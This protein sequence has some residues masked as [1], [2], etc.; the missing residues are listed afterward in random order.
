M[1]IKSSI[2]KKKSFN[3]EQLVIRDI[4]F[5]HDSNYSIKLNLDQF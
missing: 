4:N 5:Q 2:Y 1:I 3:R